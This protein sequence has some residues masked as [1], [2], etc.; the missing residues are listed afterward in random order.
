I[1]QLSGFSPWILVDFRSPRR[2][3]PNIQDGWNRKGL[4]SSGGERK[5]AFYILQEYYRQKTIVK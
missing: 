5:Q 1:P 2:V 4:I 3:L